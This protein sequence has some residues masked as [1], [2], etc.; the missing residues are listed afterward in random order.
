MK[1]AAFDYHLPQELI[2]QR[3]LRDRS[4]SR[5][6][7]L[8]RASGRI[9]H[10]RFDEMPG[11]LRRG[12]ALVLNNTR[13]FKARLIGRKPSGG[14]VEILLVR[15]GPDGSWEALIDK[16]RRLTD[17]S[18]IVIAED[19]YAQVVEKERTR[20]MVRFNRPADEVIAKYGTVPLPH[21]IRRPADAEDEETY[22]TVYAVRP[23]SV[24]APTAGL[25]FT[26]A[27]L[28]DV[29]S[30]RI[31]IAEITLHVGPGT[32]RPIR[33]EEIER[34]Q[35]DP[36]CYDV[37]AEACAAIRAAGR[38][39]GVGTTT[40]RVLEY[41]GRATADESDAEA[42]PEIR[43]GS[44]WADIF[45]YPGFRFRV[46]QALVTNFHL[47]QST[48]L[49]LVCAFAGRD[50]IFK[51]YEEAIRERYRFYSYGDAMLIM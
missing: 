36:E 14:R 30:R 23:G 45:I 21:Y 35:M 16:S 24:A 48:P 46:V 28:A 22:Q 18:R 17:G 40:T 9:E 13:V 43:P 1:R 37:T 11:L 44:G 38:V 4:S 15:S 33:T 2:A 8:D 3:P 32:F 34:H 6:L 26:P 5:L 19:T 25:H 41:L 49:L 20:I 7:V 29:R 39:V 27:V 12:D 51:A 47:P 42:R 10:R 31:P 50:L